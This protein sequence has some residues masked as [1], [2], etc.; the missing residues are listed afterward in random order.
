[1]MQLQLEKLRQ[2]VETD[3]GRPMTTDEE[4]EIMAGGRSPGVI[5]LPLASR[6]ALSMRFSSSLMFPGQEY[7]MSRGIASDESPSIFFSAFY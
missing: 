1:M 7:P 5:H 4:I 6:M 3:L 2:E